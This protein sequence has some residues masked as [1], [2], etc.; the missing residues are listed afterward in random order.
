MRKLHR[1]LD[2][3]GPLF[4]VALVI[5]WVLWAVQLKGPMKEL[6]EAEKRDPNIPYDQEQQS[7]L[8]MRR[9][10]EKYGREARAMRKNYGPKEYFAH[11][12]ALRIR[13][14]E[15]GTRPPLRTAYHFKQVM[16]E[17]WNAG[18]FTTKEIRAEGKIFSK[19]QSSTYPPSG[20]PPTLRG[21]GCWALALYFRTILLVIPYYLLSMISRKGIAETI[22]ADKKKFVCAI[23]FWPKFFFKY[24]RNVVRE[25]RVEAE[26]RMIKTIFRVLSQKETALVR[27]IANGSNQ[28]YRQWLGQKRD[29][30]RGLTITLIVTV[31]LHILPP[32]IARAQVKQSKTATIGSCERIEEDVGNSAEIETTAV[33]ILEPQATP[34]ELLVITIAEPESI[35][36]E[37]IAPK[38]I[39]RIPRISLFGKSNAA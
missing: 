17:N 35:N 15:T 22:L 3:F 30:R 24:P 10:G 39:D 31:I 34:E 28:R 13:A 29:Y 18:R 20:P 1:F 2:N 19:W 5:V 11:L 23:V 21:L 37:S 8:E 26:L 33:A 32:S 16:D 12:K 27:E 36:P 6:Y 7:I 38:E 4:K 9:L 14:S 25:I